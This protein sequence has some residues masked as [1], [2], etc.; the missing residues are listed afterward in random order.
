MMRLHFIGIAGALTAGVAKLAKEK[1]YE[2]AG[3]DRAFYPPFGEIA[4]SLRV[5]L[6]TGYDATAKDRPAD[7]YIIGNAVSR[8]NPLVESVLSSRRPYI[9]AAQWLG[10]NILA[11]KKVLAVAGT[12]GKTTTTILLAW[13]LHR[14]G[15]SP[16]FLAGGVAPNFG[17]SVCGGK[18]DL[19][20]MEAD[21][22]DSA[23]FDKRPKFL[24]YR[25]HIALLNNLEFDHA[26]IY[27]NVGEIARQFHFLLR[28]VPAN[29]RV[30]A[31]AGARHLRAA[32]DMGLYSPLSFFGGGVAEW[33]RRDGGG[34][35]MHILYRGKEM[36]NFT[37][38][39]IGA[40]NRD[41]ILAAVAAAHYAGA[42]A[43]NAGEYLRDFRPPNRRL[44]KI[45]DADGILVYD[46]FAHHPTAYRKTLEALAGEYPRKRIVA[47]F[48]PRSNTMKAGVMKR[49]LPRAFAAAHRIVAVGEQKWLADSLPPEKTRVL[50]DAAAAAEFLRKETR[51]D[52][53]IVLMSNGDFGGLPQTVAKMATN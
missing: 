22:Y 21:E 52:D 31:R 13:I 49:K 18:S 33:R 43:R 28:T 34:G 16:G 48:E 8:G 37:P 26:D 41:N 5:P 17:A 40:A 1:G 30:V 45:A 29:G 4:R 46:D 23:F 27:R 35:R 10:E 53:C 6:F 50:P 19:F 15:L 36:C 3:S 32:L 47:V 51:A 42:N 39:L 2:I 44:Q 9:S 7:C 24:H 11:D 14:A 20:V 12:H 38:P 25:P